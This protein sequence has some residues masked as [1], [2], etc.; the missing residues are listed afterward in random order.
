MAYE[1]IISTPSSKDY[2]NLC[3][4]GTQCQTQ[5]AQI[6]N[7]LPRAS[8]PELLIKKRIIRQAN[9]NK[10]SYKKA[11]DTRRRRGG[12]RLV[13]TGVGWFASCWKYQQWDWYVTA[14]EKSTSDCSSARQD[15]V[16]PSPSVLSN[17]FFCGEI[18]NEWEGW[19][20]F[21]F[22][23]G[24]NEESDSNQ[25]LDTSCPSKDR[26]T[27]FSEFLTDR[28]DAKMNKKTEQWNPIAKLHPG[29]PTT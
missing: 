12:G 7:E 15:S 17:S 27:K 23:P 21:P 25:P 6:L 13:R 28:K 19:L 11:V 8:T 14:G 4:K 9:N 1:N 26:R 5:Q 22:L 10:G 18:S 20:Y 24:E 3:W 16:S 29:R 2:G